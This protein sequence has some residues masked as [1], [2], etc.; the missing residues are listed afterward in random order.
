MK[1]KLISVILLAV[2]AVSLFAAFGAS[3]SADGIPANATEVIVVAKGDTL[4]SLCQ[5]NGFSYATYKEL[6]MKLNNISDESK[7]AKIYAGKKL[8]LPTSKAAADALCELLSI[9]TTKKN[10]W[11][12][13]DR[14]QASFRSWRSDKNSGRRFAQVLYNYIYHA[15]GRHGFRTSEGVGDELQN[16]FS[17]DPQSE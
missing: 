16:L 3:A 12:R 14:I 10:D 15:E 9:D 11:R 5:K 2:M 13:E 8:V 1:K 17:A 6:L 7:L 4:Y